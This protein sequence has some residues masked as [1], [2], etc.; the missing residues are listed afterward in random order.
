[1]RIGKASSVFGRL[2][3]IWK[4]KSIMLPVK[5]KYNMGQNITLCSVSVQHLWTRL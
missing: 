3:N 1:M 4:S 5:V 2:A